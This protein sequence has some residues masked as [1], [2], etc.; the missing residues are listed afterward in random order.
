MEKL[1]NYNELNKNR[2]YDT[3][4]LCNGIHF[5]AIGRGDRVRI[6]RYIFDSEDKMEAR[7][8]IISG[9]YGTGKSSSSRLLAE[10]SPYDCAVHIHSDDFYQYIRK[11]Y[12]APWLEGSGKQNEVMIEAV[13]AS[14]ERFSVLRPD[15]QATILRATEREQKAD[16]PLSY[17]V[18]K[19]IWRS[20]SDLGQYEANVVDTTDQTVEESIALI[21]ERLQAGEFRLEE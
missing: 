9:A 16:F 21:Q 8:V 13:A 11:G 17:E 20:F 18:I 2:V 1:L 10:K 5:N 4:D 12:I 6:C 14:A 3:L 15:E 7:I 19:N